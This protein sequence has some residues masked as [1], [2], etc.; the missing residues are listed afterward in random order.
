MQNSFNS[1]DIDSYLATSIEIWRIKRGNK[2]FNYLYWIWFKD[3]DSTAASEGCHERH[4]DF[5][6][7]LRFFRQILS[8]EH[9]WSRKSTS[10]EQDTWPYK[11]SIFPWDI[12]SCVL[13]LCSTLF[14]TLVRESA[15]ALWRKTL[16]STSK[17][18]CFFFHGEEDLM[19]WLLMCVLKHWQ[20]KIKF[21]YLYNTT[22][23]GEDAPNISGAAILVSPFP[24][25]S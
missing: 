21:N 8:K 1:P 9:S 18:E 16:Q 23:D 13:F 20:M 14:E 6:P 3:S 11:P 17:R 24:V 19:C 10:E 22:S 7:E 15:V 12:N 2:N 5:V 4:A 25:W